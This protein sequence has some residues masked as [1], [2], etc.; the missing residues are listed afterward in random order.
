MGE[1]D[2]PINLTEQEREKLESIVSYGRHSAQI[3]HTCA[4]LAER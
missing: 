4:Y 3:D 1:T 2:Y